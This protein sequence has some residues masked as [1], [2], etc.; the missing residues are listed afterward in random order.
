MLP[1][2][3]QPQG[4]SCISSTAA[5]LTAAK[6]LSNNQR[7]IFNFDVLYGPFVSALQVLLY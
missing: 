3:L 1:I 5:W 4:R 7:I 6:A 2:L